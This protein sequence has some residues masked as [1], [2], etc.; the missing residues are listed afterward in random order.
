MMLVLGVAVAGF[1]GAAQ[2][3]RVHIG[4][5]GTGAKVFCSQHSC[6][7][8]PE[9]TGCWLLTASNSTGTAGPDSNMRFNSVQG[10]LLF[11]S[12]HHCMLSLCAAVL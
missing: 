7:N 10:L 5:T 9:S 1:E 2:C 8:Q 11:L 12:R 6:R 3:T 4:R